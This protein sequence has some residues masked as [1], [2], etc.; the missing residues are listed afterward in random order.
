[1]GLPRP[2]YLVSPAL[3][4]PEIVLAS[5]LVCGLRGASYRLEGASSPDFASLHPSPWVGD[6]VWR[7]LALSRVD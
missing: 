3:S 4:C 2:V 7:V 1:M 5:R 6:Q